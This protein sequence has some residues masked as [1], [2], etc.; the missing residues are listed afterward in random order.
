MAF[1]IMK[2]EISKKRTRYL[3]NGIPPRL[4]TEIP[5]KNLCKRSKGIYGENTFAYPKTLSRYQGEISFYAKS[6]RKER[7]HLVERILCI[8]YRFE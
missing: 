1:G 2:H 8:V 5:E 3:Q 7:R 4:D 6:L